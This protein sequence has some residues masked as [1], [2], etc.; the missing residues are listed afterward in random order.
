MHRGGLPL[1]DLEE[2]L[3]NFGLFIYEDPEYEMDADY[4]FMI[5]NVKL[6]PTQVEKLCKDEDEDAS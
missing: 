4:V 2:A 1:E 5:S 6:T 3:E